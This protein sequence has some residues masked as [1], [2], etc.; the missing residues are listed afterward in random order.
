MPAGGGVRARRC[1]D[2][3]RLVPVRPVVAD[4][5]YRSG[6]RMRELGVDRLLGHGLVQ[7]SVGVDGDPLLRK[8]NVAV[9][10]A[11]SEPFQLR[12]FTVTDEPLTLCVPP[13]S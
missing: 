8:P 5:D 11:A 10:F 12:F 1:V 9:P 6:R 3:S 4:L 2:V 7:V 13:Q